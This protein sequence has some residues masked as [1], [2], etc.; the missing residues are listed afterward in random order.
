MTKLVIRAVLICFS[1]LVPSLAL[2][3]CPQTPTDCG[4]PVMNNIT[5]GGAYLGNGDA[6]TVAITP[7][8]GSNSRFLSQ[9]AAQLIN[10]LDYGGK[11]DL[12]SYADGVF[13][14]GS[15]AFSSAKGTFSLVD[16]GKPI[17][18]SGG[19]TNGTT[20]STTVAGFVNTHAITLTA[21]PA[22]SSFNSFATSALVSTGQSGAGSYAPGDTITLTGG[23]FSVATVLTV[24]KTKLISATINDAG[25]GGADTATFGP[26]TVLGT[27]GGT[28]VFRAYVT[29]VG[30]SLTSVDNIIDTGDYSTNPTDLTAEPVA[31]GCSLVGAT[32]TLKM[33]VSISTVTTPGV[34]TVAPP[35]PTLQGSTSGVGTGASFV[36]QR[37]AGGT[38]AV[39][40]DNTAAVSAAVAQSNALYTAGFHACLY[41]PSRDSR[42]ATGAGYMVVSQP[43]Q[44]A[45]SNPGCLLGDGSDRSFVRMGGAFSG[46]LF[47]WDDTWYEND[48]PL[49]G[50]MPIS[51]NKQGPY[52]RGMGVVGD[53]A[54]AAQQ[55]A[56]SFVDIVTNVLF[57]DVA[58]WYVHGYCIVGGKDVVSET[59]ATI[60][61]SRFYNVRI[62]SSG[63]PTA[64]ALFISGRGSGDSSNQIEF[65]GLQVLRC[66]GICMKL[67]PGNATIP[68]GGVKG[69]RFFSPRFERSL[70]GDD[71][72]VIGDDT[73]TGLVASVS[74]YGLEGDHS[75]ASHATMRIT[76]PDI[77]NQSFDINVFGTVGQS[78]GQGIVIDAGRA[79]NFTMGA[80]A[81]TPTYTVGPASKVGSG[82]FINANGATSTTYNVDPTS[83]RNVTTPFRYSGVPSDVGTGS[84][85]LQ[86]LSTLLG[87]TASGTDCIVIGNG[88]LSCTGTGGIINIGKQQSATQTHSILIGTQNVAN[89]VSSIVEGTGACD[90]TVIGHRAWAT[91]ALV[92]ACDNQIGQY[93]MRGISTSATP[94][95]LVTSNS[96]TPGGSNIANP[97][98]NSA[99][100]G[101]IRCMARDQATG[102]LAVW[103][104]QNVVLSKG[105]TF[106]V[107]TL[108]FSSLTAIFADAG[109][110]AWVL[111]ETADAT[112]GG[113]NLT[114]TGEAGKTIHVACSLGLL[115][116]LK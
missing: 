107:A 19:G 12:V 87:N 49:D 101:P 58:C 79:M 31:S 25:S 85:N 99:W 48:H 113:L 35:I 72:V 14:A 16:V 17:Y 1:A 71:L 28:R 33:G 66:I 62:N 80:V 106:A 98:I 63:S 40:T 53:T 83:F 2:A 93:L 6:S 38:Y 112:N 37:N 51:N 84:L 57:D 11:N 15:P 95:R 90:Q 103:A 46:N 76:S 8:G 74:M 82:L 68:L 81:G 45:K 39:G 18:I 3:S 111:A 50:T 23:T 61:E 27:T 56:F 92:V 86:A 109:A 55:N 67:D 104:D 5:V 69:L 43:T 60:G 41:F 22:T 52:V 75:D 78:S 115:M 89:S 88:T 47:S 105:A 97:P 54:S 96:P 59:N 100:V 4:S 108:K 9:R 32:L 77:T 13:T 36:L 73:R 34:W 10:V 29:I 64:P 65:F 30:G 114:F 7:S 70:D 94:V 116:E 44:F 91:G 110:A 24:L 26:C 42:Y 21:N 102:D 20:L